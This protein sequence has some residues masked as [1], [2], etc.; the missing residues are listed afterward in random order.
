MARRKKTPDVLANQQHATN[1]TAKGGAKKAETPVAPPLPNAEPSLEESASD[2]L[3][4]LFP[5]PV[6]TPISVTTRIKLTVT[7]TED[8]TR[9][10]ASSVSQALG[11]LPNVQ[12]VTEEA[13]WTLVILSVVVQSPSR[14]PGGVALSVVIVETPQG[15]LQ[16]RRHSQAGRVPAVS[17]ERLGIFHGAWLRVAA[18]TQLSRLCQQIV[19]DFDSRYLMARRKVS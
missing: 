1:R 19:A 12:V 6:D 8:L 9:E 4:M 3:A 11:T 13:D 5:H 15:Q 14:M 18:R 16:E 2:P 17:A 10:I 7:A